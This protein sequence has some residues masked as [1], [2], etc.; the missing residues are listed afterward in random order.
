MA[1]KAKV[2]KTAPAKKTSAKAAKASVAKK[3]AAPAKVVAANAAPK[4]HAK[5]SAPAK[6]APAAKKTDEKVL[7]GKAEKV[8]DKKRAKAEAAMEL[9]AGICRLP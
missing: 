6:T 5:K 1:A 7:K 2:K 9:E 8:I 3:K 4:A